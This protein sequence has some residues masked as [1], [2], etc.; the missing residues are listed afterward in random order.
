MSEDKEEERVPEWFSKVKS[1]VVDPEVPSGKK[2]EEKK[3]DLDYTPL[4]RNGVSF[5]VILLFLYL[6]IASF[7]ILSPFLK[8]PVLS[9]NMCLVTLLFLLPAFPGIFSI[10]GL[11]EMPK[12]LEYA[13]GRVFY[14]TKNN[15]TVIVLIHLV[16]AGVMAWSSLRGLPSGF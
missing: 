8:S 13:E 5:E 1:A 16:I 10:A 9:L 4:G 6:A 12:G 2:V 15:L 11:M 7:V 14:F 3:E